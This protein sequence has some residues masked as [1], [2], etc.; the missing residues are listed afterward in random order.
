V[1]IGARICAAAGLPCFSLEEKTYFLAA[2]A[3]LGGMV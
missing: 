3:V 2:F 1:K